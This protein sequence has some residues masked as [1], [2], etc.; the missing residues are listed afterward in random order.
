MCSSGCGCG[1]GGS[2]EGGFYERRKAQ[3]ERADALARKRSSG[4]P[5]AEIADL[6]ARFDHPGPPPA[7]PVYVT[8]AA[9]ERSFEAARQ[10]QF[11]GEAVMYRSVGV[12]A[13]PP[14]GAS[15]GWIYTVGAGIG[16]PYQH[17]SRMLGQAEAW[18]WKEWSL[19]FVPPSKYVYG[20]GTPAPGAVGQV[21]IG[22]VEYY[23][24]DDEAPEV[25]VNLPPVQIWGEPPPPEPQGEED[26]EESDPPDG[27]VKYMALTTVEIEPFS[28][29]PVTGEGYTVEIIDSAPK[30][31]KSITGWQ[32][33]EVGRELWIPDTFAE[34]ITRRG[35]IPAG[36]RPG[37]PPKPN[38]GPPGANVNP[39][40]IPGYPGSYKGGGGEA[41]PQPRPK[42]K[43]GLG[44]VA[45]VAAL[46]TAAAYAGTRK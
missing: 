16:G 44:P 8:Q 27:L 1:C 38:I 5:I 40:D 33:F 28:K 13:L 6:Y 2:G 14:P 32:G 35:N 12:G 39:G 30:P 36:V 37:A 45:V 31:G 19:L 17:V 34:I 25:V 46:L 21:S 41:V 29:G 4:R 10:R 9:G 26:F 7:S 23:V 18:R 20:D 42:K 22:T 11:E 43:S 24:E 3:Q 15:L